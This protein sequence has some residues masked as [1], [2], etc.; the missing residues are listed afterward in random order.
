MN[1]I[2][3]FIIGGSQKTRVIPKKPLFPNHKIRR[4]SLQET[5]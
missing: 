1:N 5:T 2:K 3:E 4:E